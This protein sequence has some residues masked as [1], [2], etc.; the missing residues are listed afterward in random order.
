MNVPREGVEGPSDADIVG[1]VRN[2]DEEAYRLLVHRYQD[3]LYR[4][5]LRMVSSPDVATDIVQASLI[6]AYRQI[7]RC[8][9]AKFGGWVYRIVTNRAKDHLKSRR[10][11]DVSLDDAPPQTGET[12]PEDE[13]HRSQIRDRIEAALA[14]L[15]KEQREAFMLKHVEG[16]SYDEMQTLLDASVPA[17]KMR[18]HRA[19]DALRELLEEVI[20]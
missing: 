11:R 9:P 12:D 17:L 8:E 2:G 10:R 6:K 7:E 20:E 15:P 16:R 3:L 18:V 4:H 13:L 19:R 1:R 5:A 14:R